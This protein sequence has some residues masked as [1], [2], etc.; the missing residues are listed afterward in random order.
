MVPGTYRRRSRLFVLILAII[1]FGMLMGWLAQLVLGQGTRPNGQSLAA[2][3]AG[4]FVG[5]LLAS[6]LAGD[7]LALQPSGIIG[8]FVGAVIVIL[9]WNAVTRRQS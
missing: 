5:G 9:A 2:G 4:S 7:G 3:V 1:A 8:T 6:L